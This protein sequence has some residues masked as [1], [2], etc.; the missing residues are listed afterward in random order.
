M[1]S[2][3]WMGFYAFC[4]AAGLLW[5]PPLRRAWPAIAALVL[6]LMVVAGVVLPLGA[7]L[8]VA[9]GL[10]LWGATRATDARRAM[11][12]HVVGVVLVL[13]LFAHLLP[14]FRGYE[15]I[16]PTRL[17]ANAT[18][19]TRW[20]GADKA[21]AGVLFLALMGPTLSTAIEWKQVLARTA[22]VAA[23]TMVSVLVVA[24]ALHRVAVAP[25]W[26]PWFVTF[27]LSNLFLTC[28]SEE[29]AFRRILQG[30]LARAFHGTR[31]GATIAVVASSVLFGL[32]HLGGGTATAAL[33]A[34]A[35][36]GY[37]YAYQATG[38]IEAAIVTHFALNLVHF[39]FLTYPALA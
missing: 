12:L 37:G 31:S 23:A 14:G 1:P 38:R 39:V 27:A 24:V 30:A 4:L 17:S 29:V 10:A 32:A 6:C 5:V 28:I 15:L 16:P 26:S 34:M 25:K 21:F 9:T 33:A 35:G 19:Y 8:L 18:P 2:L 11:A 13:G 3:P 7:A 36:I 20:F 22:P